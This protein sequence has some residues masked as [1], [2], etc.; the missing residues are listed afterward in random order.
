MNDSGRE[1]QRLR[2]LTRIMDEA[3]GI[4][5]TRFR[6]GLDGLLG[7]IPGV[8]DALSAGIAGYAVIAAARLGAPRSVLARMAGNI[9]LDTL[10]GAVPLLGDLFD[11]G[12]KANRRNL[13][14]LESFLAEPQRTRRSSRALLIGTVAGLIGVL[15][16][17]VALAIL[18]ARAAIGAFS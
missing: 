12:F 16:V 9:A 2:A 8:G 14:T 17:V 5:G 6:I 3:V 1:L 13:R 11:F 4:P 15:V 10:A 18:L 7:L